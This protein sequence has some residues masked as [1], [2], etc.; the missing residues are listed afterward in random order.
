MLFDLFPP[1]LIA[2]LLESLKQTLTMVAV[3]ALLSTVIGLPLGIL[4]VVTAPGQFLERPLLNRVIARS[5]TSC[6]RHPSLS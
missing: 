4:L 5:S 2:L 1:A 6:A 3:A